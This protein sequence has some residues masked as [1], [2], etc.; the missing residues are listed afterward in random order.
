MSSTYFK[1]PTSAQNS[2]A[3]AKFSSCHTCTLVLQ[4]SH[5]CPKFLEVCGSPGQ[6]F[7]RSYMYSGISR[8]LPQ[9]NISRGLREP[10]PNFLLP[11]SVLIRYFESHLN[12]KFREVCRSPGQIFVGRYAYSVTSR[13]PFYANIC[14][15][16]RSPGQ[17]SLS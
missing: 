15:V 10:W 11:I 3:L 8:V 4:G 12:T 13:V 2:G 16:C 14:T 17:I 9:R 6:I 5:L 7:F 1:G